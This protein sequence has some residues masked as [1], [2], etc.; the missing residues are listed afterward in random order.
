MLRNVLLVVAFLIFYITPAVA[1][2]HRLLV[3]DME[4]LAQAILDANARPES[5]HTIVAIG[6]GEWIKVP[7]DTELPIITSHVSLSGT[8]YGEDDNGP[9]QL[10]KIGPSGKVKLSGRI[11]DFVV[12]S[13]DGMK[14][15]IENEGELLVDA[16]FKFV[17][18]I[19]SCGG[20]LGT[21]FGGDTPV[22]FNSEYGR[23]N[24][25][26]A[27]F[28]EEDYSQTF[29]KTIF[30]EN[31]GSATLK[32]VQVYL[33][34]YNWPTPIINSG[35]LSL[36]NVSMVNQ[37]GQREDE[38]HSA[39]ETTEGGVTES[40]NSVYGGFSGDWCDTATSLGYNISDSSEC[41]WSEEGDITNTGTGLI[42]RDDYRLTKGLPPG[43]SALV[44]TRI[45]AAVDSAGEQF[46]PEKV[47]FDGNGDGIAHC[48][49]GAIELRPLGL[50][51]S[52]GG[53]NGLFYNPEADGHYLQVLQT[54]FTTLVVW[55]TFDKDGN[56]AWVYGT[57][58]LVDGSS[59]VAET[60]INVN[61]GSFHNG[62][63]TPSEAVYWGRIELEVHTCTDGAVAYYSN[64]PGFGDGSFN[65]RR[66]GYV[67]Q[68]GCVD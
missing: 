54:D 33:P 67:K 64:Y 10:F 43:R 56:Q 39:V 3:N 58:E 46:C 26:G 65:V 5:D 41:S 28:E 7:S 42:W 24:L 38:R 9:K 50:G 62:E 34:N 29:A 12:R 21:C 45:S 60:Y 57:G 63:F 20:R 35:Y 32:E 61:G 22:I 27:V 16:E 55:N 40:V 2:E 1:E 13:A 6:G 14:G 66:L 59:L 30:I 51:D 4:E 37:P 36:H 31:R 49:R 11:I 15:F 47:I 8:I 52:D 23:L 68:L 17:R 44:P 48:D 19:Y 18:S 25:E 53:I